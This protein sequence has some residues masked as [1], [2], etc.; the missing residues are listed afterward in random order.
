MIKN[1]KEK[2]DP[3][4]PRVHETEKKKD[5]RDPK[6]SKISESEETKATE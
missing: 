2:N 4:D 6:R 5:E 3:K 1:R